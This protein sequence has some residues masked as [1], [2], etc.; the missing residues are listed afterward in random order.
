[1]DRAA[2]AAAAAAA[3]QPDGGSHFAVLFGSFCLFFV[4]LFKEK[5]LTKK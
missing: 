3:L 4:C 2:A 5:M 1:M